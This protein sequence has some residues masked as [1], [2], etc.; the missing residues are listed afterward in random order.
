MITLYDQINI[1]EFNGDYRR[2]GRGGRGGSRGDRGGGSRGG[3]RS[4]APPVQPVDLHDAS[5]FPSLG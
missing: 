4:R 2:N 1:F 5:A 3:D